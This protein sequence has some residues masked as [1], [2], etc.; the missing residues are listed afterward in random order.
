MSLVRSLWCSLLVNGSTDDESLF[1]PGGYPDLF[2]LLDLYIHAWK[3][4]QNG[5]Y[6]SRQ[7]Q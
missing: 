4:L 7:R 1:V 2:S 6:P 3:G 5:V